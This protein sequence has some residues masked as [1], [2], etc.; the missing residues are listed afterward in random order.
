MVQ[1]VTLKNTKNDILDAYHAALKEIKTLKERSAKEIQQ[2][3]QQEAI[4]KEAGEESQATLVDGLSKVKVNIAK[5]LDE[6]SGQL[7]AQ[8]E[9]LKNL[10]DAIAIQ[11]KS[12]KDSYGIQTE[13]DTMDAL[14]LAHKKTKQQ[15]DDEIAQLRQQWQ[16]EKT[17]RERMVKEEKTQLEKDRTREVD[18]YNY[19]L[20]KTR[21]AETDAYQ[22]KKQ[23][24]ER[25]LAELKTNFEKEIADRERTVSEQEASFKKLTAEA[26]AFPEILESKI[27]Q[28]I[29]QTTLELK[30]SYE[31]QAKLKDKET[32][33]K[34][35]L[36]EQT[37]KSLVEKIAE[38]KAL[39]EELSQKTSFAN[40]QV[41]DIALKAIE[42]ASKTKL[43]AIDMRHK[44]V[45]A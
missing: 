28:A 19:T 6:I 25:E 5:S 2:A 10:E 34:I 45:E 12:L 23:Q 16:E 7:M 32:E 38:Q 40:T 43:H 8:Q 27:Q 13:L 15:L 21:Q 39:I 26:E 3:N 9:K 44:E 14:I 33:G 4:V 20:K 41:Q 18:D 1:E 29:K 11:Q 31:Y 37:N 36:Y 42:G 35:A 24:Q 17:E 22:L 30:Q